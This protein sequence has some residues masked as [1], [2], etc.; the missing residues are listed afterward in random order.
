MLSGGKLDHV[1]RL[2]QAR[3]SSCAASKVKLGEKGFI[4]RSRSIATGICGCRCQQ[5]RHRQALEAQPLSRRI[6]AMAAL[7]WMCLYHPLAQHS[8]V[9]ARTRHCAFG[10]QASA[11]LTITRANRLQRAPFSSQI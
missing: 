7:Y 3:L 11:P 10:Q 2:L 8:S 9:L 6:V 1:I 5:T 4:V